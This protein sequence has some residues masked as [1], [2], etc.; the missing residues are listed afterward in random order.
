LVSHGRDWGRW[1]LSYLQHRIIL[2]LKLANDRTV[3]I[4][5]PQLPSTRLGAGRWHHIATTVDILRSIVSIYVDSIEIHRRIFGMVGPDPALVSLY[6]YEMVTWRPS[7]GV[8]WIPVPG[9]GGPV[10]PGWIAD[11][12]ISPTVL[13]SSDIHTTMYQLSSH[14][15]TNPPITFVKAR[16][17]P[18]TYGPSPHHTPE[19]PLELLSTR[20]PYQVCSF[21]Q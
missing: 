11:I 13:S 7:I 8:C 4:A 3:D 15:Q 10:L 5:S 12:R 16:G 18:S 17:P 20:F 2:T 9:W 21:K 6:P 1:K 19:Y 14:H